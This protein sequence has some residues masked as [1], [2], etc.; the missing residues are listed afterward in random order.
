MRAPCLKTQGAHIAIDIDIAIAIDIDIDI[1]IAGYPAIWLS[2]YPAIRASYPAI[3]ASYPAI[4]L[5]AFSMEIICLLFEHPVNQICNLDVTSYVI[6]EKLRVFVI[7]FL[8]F[9]LIF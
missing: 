8:V 4:R 3:W 2:G 6:V 7:C 9:F 1:D 5:S